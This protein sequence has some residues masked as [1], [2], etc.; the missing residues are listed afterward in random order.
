MWSI[1][2]RTPYAAERNW[3]RDPQGVHWWLVA[4]RGTFRVE[5]DGRL[6][7]ADEQRPPVLA[8]EH[9][10]EPGLSS[11]LHDSDLLEHKPGTDLLV[12]GSAHAPRGRPAAAVPVV[13][14]IGALEKQLVVH[15][16]RVYFEGGTGLTTTSAQPFVEQPIQYELAFGGGDTSHPDPAR[17]SIDERNPV[18]RGFPERA[19][20][21]KNKPAHCIEYPSGSPA[22]KGPAGFGPIDRAWLPRRTLAGTYD[23]KWVESKKP[24]LPDD[25]DPR[26]GLC[27]P[28]DQRTAAPL[29]GGERV[30]VL[31]MTPEGTLVFELPRVPLR[32][33]STIGRKRHEHGARLTT[34]TIEPSERRVSVVW[35]S[36][37]RVPAPDVDYLDA[38][39]IVEEGGAK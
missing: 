37:L 5:R 20:L 1:K 12:L 16:N 2:N 17:H 31:N 22:S 36:A 24:L 3:T 34:V 11:L 6:S 4:V 15:G 39:D 32:L 9:A 35:Q 19:A 33:T 26:F 14:R 8:P 30:G 29:A 27:A 10:A 21:W 28:A 18:G 23:A 25:Y 13:L 7:L 38:T